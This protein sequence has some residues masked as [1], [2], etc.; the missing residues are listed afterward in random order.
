V[1]RACAILSGLAF[2][3][4]MPGVVRGDVTEPAPIAARIAP[5]FDGHF[6]AWL[7]LGPF[8]SASHGSKATPLPDA[9]AIDPPKLVESTLAP[10]AGTNGWIVAHTNAGAIDVKHALKSNPLSQKSDLIA[11]AAGTL[12]LARAQKIIM[13]LG[14]D[15]G[16]RVSIDGKNILSRDEA[17]PQRDDDDS[18]VMDLAAGD[19]PM[20]LK[21]HQRDGAWSFRIRF[22]DDHLAPPEGA[23]LALPGVDD[24]QQRTLAT[25]MSRGYVDFGTRDDAYVPHAHVRFTEG[26]PLG[27]PLHV[28]ASLEAGG[29]TL[30]DVD[31][32]DATLEGPDVDVQLPAIS[33][34]DLAAIE[35][36]DVHVRV[37]IAGRVIAPTFHP[38]KSIREAIKRIDEITARIAK[39]TRPAWLREDTIESLQNARN[40]LAGE[41]NRGDADVIALTNE[42]RE[43]TTAADALEHDR[44]P[45]AT[46]TGPMRM[47]FRSPVDNALSEY[48][49]YVPPSY[50]PNA[51]RK[52]PLVVALH[53]LNGRPMA[54]MRWFFG[55]DDPQKEQDYE[56]RHVDHVAPLEAFVVTPNAYG[57]SMY[58][59]LGEDDPMRVL[60]RV[61]ARFPIDE[62]RVTITGPSMGGIGA[63]AIPFRHP[64]RFAA[65]EPL[66]G[67]HSYFVRRDIAGRP[68]RPWER[69]LAEERSNVDWAS[70]GFA[71]PLFVV[72]GTKDLPVANSGVLIDAYEKMHY[73]IEHEH[74]ELGH[75]VWQ[76]TYENLRGAKWLIDK[77]RDPHPR[78][79]KFRT[80]RLR[81]GASFWARIDELSAPDAWGDLDAQIT[82]RTS[83]RAT[84]KD[85]TE[86]AFERDASLVDTSAPI[87]VDID[88]Q[89]LSFQ[90]KDPIVMHATGGTWSAGPA[91]HVAD[92]KRGEITGPIRD[93]FHAPLLFV[94]GASDPEQARANEEVARAWA[95]IRSGVSVR[96]PVISDVEFFARGENLA[97]DRALF[98][99]GNAKSNLV[100]R[101][102]EGDLPIRVDGDAI[103]IG[104]ERITGDEVG[105]AFIRPN[106]KRSDRYL[107]VVEGTTA[108]G[109]WRS[110]SL[111][112]LL[113][114]FVVWD[115]TVAP[116]RNQM[117][118]GAGALRAGGFFAE[119]WSLPARIDD[120]LARTQRPA[121]KTEYEATPYLP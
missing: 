115:R 73:S 8:E 111:P 23:W 99:V 53:G 57:N 45:Y 15:D 85:A 26:A 18:V 55:Q 61:M 84:T 90:P 34:A 107:V 24:T 37:T 6:G 94:W 70:N 46:R 102:F 119:D 98:L 62:N 14:S 16:V 4:T 80:V 110:L 54:M 103:V 93:A 65:A 35:D 39:G 89:S 71:L 9:L 3:V 33:G 67:Y 109:T 17:R 72:H 32:G 52:Y 49:L 87:T 95:A 86:I 118:L 106:P 59:D 40:R 47:A 120:P 42:T 10:R 66:C 44:D 69:V 31:A 5:S 63:A 116:A 56:E 22:V 51:K 30:F 50:V 74:P 41:Q 104:Q 92:S 7:L 77:R 117:L 88:G 43:L 60:D 83:I 81:D 64:D 78:H 21:L 58:R 79:V 108:L 82:S 105:A 101:H 2:T 96:Y 48:G 76:A 113:P 91:K 38:R 75:N 121:P 27:V 100:V 97:N 12:H 25:D 29:V 20:L 114:D 112:D 68:M 13:L 19:H 11:Y 1:K 28:T 36:K